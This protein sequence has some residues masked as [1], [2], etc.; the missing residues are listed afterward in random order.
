MNKYSLQ[1]PKT[2]FEAQFGGAY[3]KDERTGGQFSSTVPNYNDTV[4]LYKIG[5]ANEKWEVYS[6]TGYIFKNR[7]ATSTG[8]Q[9][10]YLNHTQNNNYGNRNYYG[11][12]KTFYANYLFETYLGNTFTTF[13]A[14]A[15]FMGD[16]VDEKLDSTTFNRNE[17]VA[18]MYTEL[19]HNQGEKFN[20]IAGLRADYHNY[21]GLFFT[22]RLHLRYALTQ[23]SVFRVSGGKALRTASLFTDNAHLMASSRAWVIEQSDAKLPYGLKPETAW[24]YGLNFTQKFKINYRE[25][26]ITLDAYRTEFI[27]QV[28]SDVDFNTQAVINY[29]LNGPSYSNT[30]QFEFNMEPKKRFFLKT[31]YRYVDT[32]V[33]YKQGLLEKAMVAKHRAFVNLSYETRNKHWQIDFTTQFNGAKRLPGTASNPVEYQRAAYSPDYFN[34]LGQITY[35]TKIQGADFHIYLGVENLLNYKQTDPI[36]ASDAPFSKYFDASMVWGPI[37]G[38]MLYF[39]VRLKKK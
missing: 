28:V 32:K 35:L 24:N 13:K 5:L 21:Y 27:D 3:L 37:Y 11:A 39:G 23:N 22:P 2:G 8:L 26:Y 36:V 34:L 25:A 10:S 38:R 15:S 16:Q 12:Q 31:A 18:G 17:Q 33:T 4:P 20:V 19:A 6:K 9:L 1:L 7:P 29:N 14:G 30:M